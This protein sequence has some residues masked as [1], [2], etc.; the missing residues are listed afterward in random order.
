MW[1]TNGSHLQNNIKPSK[2]RGSFFTVEMTQ[3][4]KLTGRREL[5]G[6]EP[7]ATERNRVTSLL[8]LGFEEEVCA[9][10][11]LLLAGELREQE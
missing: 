7:W 10:M 1:G 9:S 5:I 11:R 6:L 4:P 8:E 2:K 3:Q